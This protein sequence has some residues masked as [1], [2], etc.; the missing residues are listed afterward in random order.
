[1]IENHF[2]WKS[3]S[4]DQFISWTDSLLWALQHAI[5]KDSRGEKDI[6]I[7]ILDTSKIETCSF[8]AASDL[9]R[10]YSIRDERE[11]AHRY[12][13]SEYLYHGGIFVHG[14]SST[15]SL[16]LILEYGLFRLLPEM[17]DKEWKPRLCKAV[18]NFRHTMFRVP[19]SVTSIEGRTALQIASLFEKDF[20]MPVMVA[21]LSLRL[22]APDDP[23]FVKL[24]TDY[25]G[26]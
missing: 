24:V 21:L 16:N 7:C 15:V 1:M 19:H 4:N 18:E 8:F 5:S 17:D 10:I 12:Y 23:H 13:I 14:S 22:R 25:A 6:Q 20:A 11:L 9:L 3:Y 2:Q 26:R